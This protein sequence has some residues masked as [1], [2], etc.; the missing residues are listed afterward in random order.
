MTRQSTLRLL[1]FHLLAS[2][3]SQLALSAASGLSTIQKALPYIVG[4][5]TAP[6]GIHPDTPSSTNQSTLSI[7][8]LFVAKSQPRSPTSATWCLTVLVCAASL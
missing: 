5:Q 6:F 8:A 3:A 4:S 1:A 7:G 2:A